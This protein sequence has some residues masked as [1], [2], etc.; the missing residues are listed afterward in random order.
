MN[1]EI[2]Y[3]LKVDKRA[4]L[5]YDLQLLNQIKSFILD[6]KFYFREPMLPISEL[7]D[8]LNISLGQVEKAYHQLA[9]ENYLIK[10]E[11]SYYANQFDLTSGFFKQ[12]VRLYDAIENLGLSPTIRQIDQRLL[13]VD[14]K[15][16]EKTQFQVDD[17]LF[18]FRSVYC[19]NDQPLIIYD[20][21]LPLS[22]FPKINELLP[23]D[24]P[25]YKFLDETYGQLVVASKRLITVSNLDKTK[26]DIFKVMPETAGYFVCAQAY[27]KKLELL[28]YSEAWSSHNYVFEFDLNIDEVITSYKSMNQNR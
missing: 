24:T 10:E 27:N 17:T 19:G 20:S 7:A 6:R 12:V 22:L 11:S 23:K 9:K 15:L 3:T 8:L 26:A 21:Y 5:A 1:T 2:Y 28:E 16:A 13:K 25:V 18:Y 4:S 14:A